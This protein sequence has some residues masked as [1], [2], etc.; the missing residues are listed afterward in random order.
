MN[1]GM[2]LKANGER[3]KIKHTINN[4]LIKNLRGMNKGMNTEKQC[5]K[6]AQN[7]KKRTEIE[8]CSKSVNYFPLNVYR[9]PFLTGSFKTGTKLATI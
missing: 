2:N 6:M 8:Y 5:L 9:V 3:K 4:K 7:R 1:W